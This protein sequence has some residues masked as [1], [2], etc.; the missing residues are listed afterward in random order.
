MVA[1]SVVV[2]PVSME[3]ILANPVKIC[4]GS[5]TATST[6]LAATT[7]PVAMLDATP[8]SSKK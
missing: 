7:S 2:F 3:D 4:F 6:T 8:S 5:F 1:R